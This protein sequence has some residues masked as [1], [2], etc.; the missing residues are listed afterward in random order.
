MMIQEQ[1]G[2]ENYK[3]VMLGAYGVGKTRLATRFYWGSFIEN[4]NLSSFEH[5]WYKV[6]RVDGEYA[7]FQVSDVSVDEINLL[8]PRVDEIVRDGKGFIFVYDITDQSSF[9][10][11]RELREKLDK[12][13]GRGNHIPVILVG[14]KADQEQKRAVLKSDAKAL[15]SSWGCRYIEASAKDNVNCEE[16]F[17]ECIREIR[18]LRWDIYKHESHWPYCTIL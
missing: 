8:D 6:D 4:Y 12:V 17:F 13:K 9:N 15:A 14:S 3:I 7:R 18:R 10:A 2:A 5:T 11:L 1:D 16:V